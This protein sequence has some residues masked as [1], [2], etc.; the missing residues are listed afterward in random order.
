MIDRLGL[1]VWPIRGIGTQVEAFEFA[2][3]ASSRIYRHDLTIDRGINCI[4]LFGFITVLIEDEVF[5]F[6]IREELRQY[7]TVIRVVL[8]LAAVITGGTAA[9]VLNGGD[10]AW[11][12]QGIKAAAFLTFQHAI[13]RALALAQLAFCSGRIVGPGIDNGIVGAVAIGI[14]GHAELGFTTQLVVSGGTG[15][16]AGVSLGQYF[17]ECVV[18]E[19]ANAL[20]RIIDAN[21]L[22]E[23]VVGRLDL[24]AFNVL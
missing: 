23:R 4:A 7:P 21:A 12:D 15:D 17:T 22:A 2:S 18:S 19:V 11:T 9:G 20:V 3:W 16:A 10:G 24:A 1:T 5:T 13:N 14:G 6:T 8:K